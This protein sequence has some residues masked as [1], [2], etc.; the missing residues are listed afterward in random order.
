VRLAL[1]INEN[2]RWF[3]VAM[4]DA[5]LMR[6]MDRAGNLLGVAVVPNR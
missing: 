3:E 5:P 1:S 4:E 6:V 2:V